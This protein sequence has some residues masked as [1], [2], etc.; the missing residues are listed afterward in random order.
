MPKT[1]LYIA[2]LGDEPSEEAQESAF[3]ELVFDEIIVEDAPKVGRSPKAWHS[4][5]PHLKHNDHL[6]LYCLEL[7]PLKQPALNKALCAM[8]EEGVTI[9]LALPE[10][11]VTPA[12]DDPVFAMIRAYEAHRR[13]LIGRSVSHAL[14]GSVRAGRPSHLS[15]DQLHEI[16]R[17][18]RDPTLTSDEICRRLKTTRSTLYKFLAKHKQSADPGEKVIDIDA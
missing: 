10:L 9:H 18:M 2:P 14:K 16:H 1:R 6:A 11:V 4:L 17:M 7:V 13:A 5:L 8:L 12:P 15:P 3:P